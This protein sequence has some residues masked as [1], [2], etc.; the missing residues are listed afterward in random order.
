MKVCEPCTDA[1]SSSQSTCRSLFLSAYPLCHSPRI[2]RHTHTHASP[3]NDHHISAC[4][5]FSDSDNNE[6]AVVPF[7]SPA[8]LL[9][10][11]AHRFIKHWPRQPTHPINANTHTHAS[12]KDLDRP[13]RFSALGQTSVLTDPWCVKKRNQC[14]KHSNLQEKPRRWFQVAHWKM[15]RGS[16]CERCIKR[17]CLWDN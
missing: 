5:S 2:H 7:S 8:F 16:A 1:L 4:T 13:S 11:C 10:P 12:K 6:I 15:L 17:F 14:V 9:L 3:D